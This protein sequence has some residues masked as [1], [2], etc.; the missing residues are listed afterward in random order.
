M[1]SLP[2]KRMILSQMIDKVELGSGYDVTV[3]LNMSYQ[4]FLD[5]AKPDGKAEITQA[6]AG[7]G[8]VA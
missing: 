4:Q 5:L 8:K 2:R 3:R 1:A 6:N 7:N